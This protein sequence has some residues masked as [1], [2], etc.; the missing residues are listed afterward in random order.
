MCEKEHFTLFV[1]FALIGDH[2]GEMLGEKCEGGPWC[3]DCAMLRTA[4]LFEGLCQVAG[5]M[6][7]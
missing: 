3:D 5:T 7:T 2:C 4:G 6:S 1:P